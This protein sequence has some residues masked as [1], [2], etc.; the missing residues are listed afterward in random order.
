MNDVTVLIMKTIQ[1]ILEA[2][3]ETSQVTI[4]SELRSQP[5]IIRQKSSSTNVATLA[6]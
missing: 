2:N 3:I 4:S 5:S 1:I 6:D